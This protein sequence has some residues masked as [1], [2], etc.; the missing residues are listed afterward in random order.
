MQEIFE[1]LTNL[2]QENGKMILEGIKDTLYMTF[3]ATFVSYIFGLPIGILAEVSRKGGISPMPTLNKILGA[4]INIGRSI[5]FIILLVAVMPI[6]RSIV[7]TTLGPKAATVPLIIAAIPF[8]ARLVESSLREL[9]GGVIE[10]AKAMGANDF[11]IIFKVMLPES[12]PSLVLG[13]SLATI[14]LIGYTAMAGTVGGGGLGDIA[15]RFGYYRYQTDIMLVTIVL[16]VLIVQIIQSVGNRI[17]KKID[18][19]EK[20]EL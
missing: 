2:F 20:G 8:V 9:D 13:I 16:L 19:R 12:L 1:F 10:A 5:P 18:K 17:S 15:I 7:G 4:I 3:M 6:T 14:T 11:Q